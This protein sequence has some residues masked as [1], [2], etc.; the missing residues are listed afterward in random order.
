M[1][2][3]LA[4]NLDAALALHA[5]GFWPVAIYPKDHVVEYQGG[6]KATKTGKEPIGNAWGLDRWTTKLLRDRFQRTPKAGVGVC[7]G[8][9]RGPGDT[10]LIDAEGDGDGADESLMILVGGECVETRGWGSTRGSHN[11]FTV[12]GPRLLGLLA[13]AGATE[14]TGNEAGVYHLPELPGLELRI[15]GLNPEGETKQIQSVTPPTI[16]DN[17]RPREWNGV[18]EIAAL[19]EAAYELLEAIA[20]SRR[21][22]VEAEAEKAKARPVTPH[23]SNGHG[24]PRPFAGTVPGGFDKWAQTALSNEIAEFSSKAPMD[25]HKYLLKCTLKLA[26]LVKAGALTEAECIAGL[27]DG[28]MANGMGT[29]RFFEVEEAWASALKMATARNLSHVGAKSNAG[30]KSQAGNTTA[31]QQSSQQP[32]ADAEWDKLTDDDLGILSG[33]Q[34]DPTPV[35]WHWKERLAVKKMNL[36]VGEGK[37]GKTQLALYVVATTTTGGDWCDGSGAA[38]QG[39]A[40]ILSAEDDPEDTLAPRLVA[41]GANMSKVKIIR[42]EYRITRPGKDPVIN[43]VTFQDLAYWRAVFRR[44]PDTRVFL[45]DPLP[46]YLGRGVNDH[47]NAEIRSVLTPFLGLVRDFELAMLSIS[48]L[49]KSIDPG[50]PISHRILGSVAY[51]NL[52]RSIH[53]VAKDKNNPERRLFMQTDNTLARSDLPSVAFTLEPRDVVNQKTGLTFQ[54]W[55]PK[56][57]DQTVQVDPADVLNGVGRK[58]RGPAPVQTLKLAKFLLDLLRDNGPVLLGKIADDVGTKGY[59]GNMLSTA[60][61]KTKWSGFNNLYRA[62]EQ[63]PKLPAPDEG[64]RIM[65]S[66]DDPGLRS[67]DGKVRWAAI[68]PQTPTTPY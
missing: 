52:A 47:K 9:G 35:D 10:W 18:D 21:M 56:F 44:F 64:W 62:I 25:R 2:T 66:K 26:S 31:G 40:I 41:M 27:K 15:G 3:T 16:G 48:H 1:T 60:D 11:L 65:T 13:T 5:A 6:R 36:I 24:S 12:D 67:V 59:L 19:P 7:M 50:K 45:A 39:T 28:A 38:Q 22:E 57:E 58:P 68:G 46:A 53:F 29:G 20:E 4:S 23:E 33:D 17:G 61:G 14:G 49:N 32:L 51:G 8:P 30:A 43:P 34:I 63:V 42:A 54:I 37:Q 55:V